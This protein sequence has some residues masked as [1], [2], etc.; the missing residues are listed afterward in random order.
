VLSVRSQAK[1]QQQ[2]AKVV[3]VHPLRRSNLLV[4]SC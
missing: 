1:P 4:V 2:Q 3:K